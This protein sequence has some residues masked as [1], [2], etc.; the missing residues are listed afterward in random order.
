[1]L[2]LTKQG[3]WSDLRGIHVG[4]LTICVN[5]LKEAH[6]SVYIIDSSVLLEN[7]NNFFHKH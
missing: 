5:R 3:V 7:C 2:S 6:T 4:S 1:M